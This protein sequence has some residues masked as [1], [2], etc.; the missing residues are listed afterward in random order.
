MLKRASQ[1]N[2]MMNP[3]NDWQQALLAAGMLLTG[4]DVYMRLKG[5]VCCTL[6][7][8]FSRKVQSYKIH[9]ILLVFRLDFRLSVMLWPFLVSLLINPFD[10]TKRWMTICSYAPSCVISCGEHFGYYPFLPRRLGSMAC[11]SSLRDLC[12]DCKWHEKC[13]KFWN[14]LATCYKPLDILQQILP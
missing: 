8:Q 9:H 2:M 13:S 11:C 4:S 5:G 6:I 1:W 3:V 14:G 12:Y 7:L 10:I